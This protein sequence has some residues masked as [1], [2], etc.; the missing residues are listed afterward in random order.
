MRMQQKKILLVFA[1][2]LS[3]SN[4]LEMSTLKEIES[5]VHRLKYTK[6]EK[7]IAR[8][9]S[10]H[11]M[12]SEQNPK[13]T[14]Q[15]VRQLCRSMREI[16]YN[17]IPNT[18]AAY[19]EE[20]GIGNKELR[21]KIDQT[22]TTTEKWIT[23]KSYQALELFPT[24][25]HTAVIE[26]LKSLEKKDFEEARI[27]FT[28]IAH[29]M[30][31]ALNDNALK[32]VTQH[33]R[34]HAKD[35]EEYYVLSHENMG[36]MLQYLNDDKEQLGLIAMIETYFDYIDE[37]YKDTSYAK[38]FLLSACGYATVFALIAVPVAFFVAKLWSQYSKIGKFYGQEFPGCGSDVCYVEPKLGVVL[39]GSNFEFYD[40]NT[41]PV[42]IIGCSNVTKIGQNLYE[43]SQAW[44]NV[45]CDRANGIKYYYIDTQTGAV[46]SSNIVHELILQPKAQIN[47]STS[48]R[49]FNELAST[50]NNESGIVASTISIAESTSVSNMTNGTISSAVFFSATTNQTE[51]YGSLP[52]PT[53]EIGTPGC[54][55]NK[56]ACMNETFQNTSTPFCSY[57]ASNPSEIVP[58]CTRNIISCPS[59]NLTI[60][61]EINQTKLNCGN[62]VVA[63]LDTFNKEIITKSK[64]ITRSDSETASTS[65]SASN[66]KSQSLTFSNSNSDSSTA[67]DNISLS[68]SL[69]LTNSSEINITHTKSPTFI[70]LPNCYFKVTLN[71]NEGAFNFYDANMK[72][73]GTTADGSL[74]QVA[75]QNLYFDFISKP[76]WKFSSTTGVR[77]Y[78]IDTQTGVVKSSNNIDWFTSTNKI[79]I[80]ASM[81]TS[82]LYFGAYNVK[83]SGSM[84]IPT[85]GS[86]GVPRCLNNEIACTDNT[87]QN[88]SAPFCY[89]GLTINSTIF[90]ECLEN[91]IFCNDSSITGITCDQNNNCG[92]IVVAVPDTPNKKIITI[93]KQITPT[94]SASKSATNLTNISTVL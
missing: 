68:H 22:F 19:L 2:L 90:P 52:N 17:A 84:L 51:A 18:V 12:L 76:N 88:L 79:N 62:I 55:N 6:H 38:T 35:P 70:A 81:S 77:Y 8:F 59:S 57:N 72:L 23:L 43:D 93:S 67:S 91:V 28:K 30:K 39:S 27:Q 69:E 13:I 42:A 82:S 53:C 3:H 64:P 20:V 56:I 54:L 80:Y 36:L 15:S 85:C 86:D 1:C 31:E 50:Y 66:N 48:A 94:A 47:A 41:N 74:A 60:C 26:F 10:M 73:L 14:D 40:G 24:T 37:V 45:V 21:D 33:P 49:N 71:L 4:P 29:D 87:L 16:N 65:K 61:D 34:R 75:N 5:L 63:V 32:L 89:N 78:Y 46:T 11:K 44:P 92:N 7:I 9:F 58:Q 25:H 83:P